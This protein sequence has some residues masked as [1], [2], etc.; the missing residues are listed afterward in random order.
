MFLMHMPDGFI[1][2]PVA[3]L[4]WVIT[5]GILAYS[6]RNSMSAPYR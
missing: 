5:A 2:A 4:F 3:S 1:S 6:A